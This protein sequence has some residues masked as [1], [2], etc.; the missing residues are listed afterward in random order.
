M[1]FEIGQIFITL[2][3]LQKRLIDRSLRAGYP[4]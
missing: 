4:N 2:K 3:F 1:F